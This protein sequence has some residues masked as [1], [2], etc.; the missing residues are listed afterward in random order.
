MRLT[1]TFIARVAYHAARC[2]LSRPTVAEVYAYRAHV[3]RAMDALLRG[4]PAATVAPLVE[5]G[6]QHEQQH[7]ELIVT[8]LKFNLSVNPLRPPCHP[9][10]IPAGEAPP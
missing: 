8:D 9:V 2:H 7:Q 5:L 3:G 1:P 10:T 6:L 4:E